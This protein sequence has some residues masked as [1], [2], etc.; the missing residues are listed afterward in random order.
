MGS[1][2]IDFVSVKKALQSDSCGPHPGAGSCG[3]PAT[4]GQGVINALGLADGACVLVIGRFGIT[5]LK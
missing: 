2:V 1:S 3:Q 4:Q 5:G